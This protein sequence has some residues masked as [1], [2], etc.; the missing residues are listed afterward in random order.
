MVE[1]TGDPGY[2]D[3]LAERSQAGPRYASSFETEAYALVLCVALLAERQSRGSYLVCS[4]SQSALAALKGGELKDHPILWRVREKL[5]S[6][7]GKV[8]FQWVPG[9]CGLPG[10]ETAEQVAKEV[11]EQ[12][13]S[14]ETPQVAPVTF[15]AAK[16]SIK[17]GG[18]RANTA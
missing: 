18:G 6:V 12:G 7:P 16:L 2:P 10:N 5:R 8:A 1:T 9:H 15:K 14:G 17:R 11:A 3:F 4:D 13:R